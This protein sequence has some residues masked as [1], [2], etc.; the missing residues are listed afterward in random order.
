MEKL[1]A[2]PQYTETFTDTEARLL[3]EQ[4]VANNMADGGIALSFA[5]VTIEEYHNTVNGVKALDDDKAVFFPL[6][7]PDMFQT[8][9]APAD[10][11][12]TVNTIGLPR[13]AKQVRDEWNTKVHMVAQSNPV[14]FVA[15]P[16]AICFAHT[17]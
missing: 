15:R 11:I 8:W 2:H 5:G 12:E 16:Q 14:N 17:T 1:F 6:G 10:Y 4:Q 9:F 7:V 13:Y 3:R